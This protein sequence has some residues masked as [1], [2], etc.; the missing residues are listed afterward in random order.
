[1]M[2]PPRHSDSP[3]LSNRDYP[4]RLKYCTARSCF[5]ASARVPNV[6]RFFRLPVFESFLREYS[7]YSPDLSF[8]II[9]YLLDPGF[10]RLAG[11][12]VDLVQPG[13]SLSG[14]ISSSRIRL[15]VA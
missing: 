15:P 7:R 1:M 11:D 8:L 2:K 10:F 3:E 6:P 4:L 14:V 9:A 13:S 5:S 12:F